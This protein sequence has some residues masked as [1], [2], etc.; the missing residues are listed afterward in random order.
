MHAQHRLRESTRFEHARR[1]GRRWSTALLTLTAVG[2]ESAV[3]RVGFAIPRQA[4]TAVVR[5]R[6]RRRLREI[7]R[8]SLPAIA[9]GWDLVV[10]ARPVA[11]QADFAALAAAWAD[12]LRRARLHITSAP[13]SPPETPP[14]P[15]VPAAA[16]QTPYA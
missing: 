10:G 7:A 9:P 8:R 5:S 3:T 15:P 2:N 14:A 4:G 1:Q 11:A 6:L 13:Q 12:L 16:S